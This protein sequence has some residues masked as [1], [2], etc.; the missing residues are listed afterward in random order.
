MLASGHL[1]RR[2]E[3]FAVPASL[4]RQFDAGEKE[5]RKVL[6]RL[7]RPL[8][9]LEKTLAGAL[10]TAE[11][12]MLYQFLKLRAK[13]GRAADLR[14]GV[15]DRHLQSLTESLHPRRDLQERSLSLL[16]ILAR[17]GLEVLGRLRA[18]I[19]P[20]QALHHVVAL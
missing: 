15:V 16:P 13:A 7:R 8:S 6:G 18:H 4:A 2:I 19:S 14:C 17:N 20:D 9:R 11:R 10:E 5:I 1:R 12:K 3:R